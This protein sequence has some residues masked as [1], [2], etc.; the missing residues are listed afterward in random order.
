M[1]D[2]NRRD[3]LKMASATGVGG[4]MLLFAQSVLAQDSREKAEDKRAAIPPG[5]KRSGKGRDLAKIGGKEE[6]IK[7]LTRGSIVSKMKLSA[8]SEFIIVDHGPHSRG[9]YL[10]EFT[11][12]LGTAVVLGQVQEGDGFGDAL[13]STGG[14]AIQEAGASI[15]CR[16]Y[17]SISWSENDALPCFGRYIR[18]F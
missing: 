7:S 8:T 18:I 11:V 13:F 15:L 5:Y 1:D 2:V 10:S 14:I 12:P 3:A 4:G 16:V 17:F 6:K 9:T